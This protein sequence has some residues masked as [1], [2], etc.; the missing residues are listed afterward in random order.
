MSERSPKAAY[1]LPN[2]TSGY[3]ACDSAGNVIGFVSWRSIAN[4]GETNLI[5]EEQ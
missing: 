3:T 2:R 1:Y 5:K 4:N